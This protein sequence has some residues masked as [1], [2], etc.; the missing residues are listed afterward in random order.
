VADLQLRERVG[1]LRGPH[2]L[3][4]EDLRVP[5]LDDDGGPGQRRELGGGVPQPR[6]EQAPEEVRQRLA[7]DRRHQAV[8][9]DDAVVPDGE[10]PGHRPDLLAA[11][12]VRVALVRVDHDLEL[13]V[14]P[15]R[16]GRGCAHAGAR[17]LPGAG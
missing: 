10:R 11:E 12:A 7:L 4:G 6:V 1:D 17:L 16:A 9:D 2:P 14:G 3:L 5:V 15:R 8:P 13:A